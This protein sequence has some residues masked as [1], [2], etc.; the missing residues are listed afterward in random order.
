MRYS[1]NRR[2]KPL[3]YCRACSMGLLKKSGAKELFD[4]YKGAQEAL[5]R[6]QES[7]RKER[8]RLAQEL[9]LQ[10]EQEKRQVQAAERRL[11]R[12]LKKQVTK[13]LTV[14]FDGKNATLLDSN[15][16]AII[17][18]LEL[19]GF[20][21]RKF[22][23]ERVSAEN[24]R[25]RIY[26]R[27]IEAKDPAIINR[28]NNLKYEL[29]SQLAKI[30]GKP[31]R[32]VRENLVSHL[33]KDIDR[34]VLLDSSEELAEI[35]K[36]WITLPSG[37]YIEAK[38]LFKDSDYLKEMHDLTFNESFITRFSYYALLLA[39]AVDSKREIRAD[40]KLAKVRHYLLLTEEDTD[41]AE[42][43][44]DILV[45]WRDPHSN[46]DSSEIDAH[47][48]LWIASASGQEF[49]KI[50][51]DLV[52]VTSRLQRKRFTIRGSVL[53]KFD[54]YCPSLTQMVKALQLMEY[55]A[56]ISGDELHISFE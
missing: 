17:S 43:N 16:S 23:D 36:T 28:L 37:R 48:L 46:Q 20:S 2:E 19:L 40:P 52:D 18:R 51:N 29:E 26:S 39:R 32:W 53:K 5:R 42:Y 10:Q 15:E 27:T 49:V 11:G 31:E 3:N 38:R 24:D 4:A 50:F 22:Y 9:K 30:T 34:Q 56:K 33:F 1:C 55:E 44:D 47:L 41:I 35:L 14:A 54:D 13:A 25:T 21:I 12:D 8:E 6:E 7:A 45:T